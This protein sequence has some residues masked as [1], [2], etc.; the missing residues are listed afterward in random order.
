M[1]I[2]L[3]ARKTATPEEGYDLT[4][5]LAPVAV[6]PMQPVAEVRDRLRPENA[7]VS[8]TLI[9]VSQRVANDYRRGTI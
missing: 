6:K 8:D 9:A 2:W 3:P 7:E 1:T 5:K 4:V